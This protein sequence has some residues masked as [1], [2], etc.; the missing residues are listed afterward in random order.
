MTVTEHLFHHLLGA[1]NWLAL[2]RVEPT[3]FRVL[4]HP[5]AWASQVIPDFS[6]VSPLRIDARKPVLEHFLRDAQSTWDG[7]GPAIA[8]SGFWTETDPAGRPWHLKAYALRLDDRPLLLIQLGGDDVDECAELLQKAREGILRHDRETKVAHRAQRELGAKLRQSELVRDDLLTI[9][10]QLGLATLL[11]DEQGCVTFMSHAARQLLDVS[12]EGFWGQSWEHLCGLPKAERLAVT[13]TMRQPPHQ[14]T[15]VVGHL[16][17]PAHRRLWVEIEVQDDPRDASRKIL[18]FHD[19]TETHDLRRLL[20]EKSHFHDL[21]GRSPVMLTIYRLVQD[22]A[23]VDSMVLIEGETGTGKEL[24]ARAIHALSP[25]QHG[26]FIAANCAGFTDSLLG[27][28]LFGHKK[29]AFTGAIEDHQGLFESAHHGTLFLDE[30]GDVPSNVQT[31]LLRVLQEREITRLGEAKPRKVDVRVLAA[32]HHNLS[33]DVI[34]GTFRADLLYRIRV[35][36]IQLPPLRK[37]LEDLPALVASFLAEGRATMGK[38][39]GEVSREAMRVMMEHRWPGNVRELK[40][41]I[42]FAM[43]HCKGPVIQVDDL[44]SELRSM[45]VGSGEDD[46]GPQDDRTRLLVALQRTHGSRTKAA[47]LLG[48]SRATFYRRLAEFGLTAV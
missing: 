25:R 23:R 13:K 11:L 39:V 46:I 36:R 41:A 32:T 8:R 14:R 33:E 30:I 28:Q 19:T 31:S 3:L 22:L 12:S 42:E 48:M 16:E 44:P 34:K 9:L 18:F 40:S 35:A 15:R 17:T 6:T 47:R 45:G 26:P 37:R 43:I 1:L 27:S 20:D 5:P 38:A 21:V 10:N 7:H 29:G 4:G 2:E 24:I